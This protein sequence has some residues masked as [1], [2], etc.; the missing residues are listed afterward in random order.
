MDVQET[1]EM[2]IWSLGIYGQKI[3]F[4]L[5]RKAGGGK[6]ARQGGRVCFEHSSRLLAGL[7]VTRGHAAQLQDCSIIKWSHM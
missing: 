4:R 1:K 2:P 3:S 6:S 7:F 5:L